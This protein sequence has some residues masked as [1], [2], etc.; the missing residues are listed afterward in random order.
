MRFSVIIPA[1]NS[2]KFIS[3]GLDSIKNQSFTDFELIVV[4]DRCTD[5]TKEIAESYGAKT[6]EVDF[7]RDGLTRNAGLDVAQGEY[8]L[9]LD[10]DDNFLHE[11]VFDGIDKKLKEENEPDILVFSFVW[12]GVMLAKPINPR[13]EINIACWCKAFKRSFTNGARFSD[14]YS[15]SDLDFHKQIMAKN[16][17][18]AYWDFPCVFYN[19]LCDGSIS[20]ESGQTYEKTKRY[21]KAD[22]EV[23]GVT[24]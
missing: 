8:V 5:R 16:P 20:K 18:I 7:G 6:L 19:Y 3:K 2:E 22:S 11:F 1:H 9:W 14:V 15:V 12:H 10:Q 23:T 17:R 13:G 21:F 24:F 4:C